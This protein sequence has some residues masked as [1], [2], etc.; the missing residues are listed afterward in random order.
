MKLEQQYFN[1]MQFSEFVDDPDAS[2]KC[3]EIAENFAIGFLNWYGERTLREVNGKTTKQ[4]LEI[5]KETL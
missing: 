1:E 3:A 5:Y 2:K 4:L